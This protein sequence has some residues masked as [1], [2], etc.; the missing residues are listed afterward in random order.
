MGDFL[1]EVN[2]CGNHLL[3]L[4]SRGNAIIAEILRLSEMIPSVFKS[5]SKSDSSKYSELIVDFAYFKN[6]DTFESK[7]EYDSGLQAKD[8]EIR[9]NYLGIL[10]NFYL[11]FESVHKYIFDL[12]DQL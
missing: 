9:E 4:V 10:T 3:Q 8:D 11:A 7:I 2:I 5:D 6:R 12:N 1:D